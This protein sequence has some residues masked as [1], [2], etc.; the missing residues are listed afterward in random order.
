MKF[1]NNIIVLTY[2]IENNI[3]VER[4]YKRIFFVNKCCVL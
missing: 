1:E 3:E 2:F 4:K